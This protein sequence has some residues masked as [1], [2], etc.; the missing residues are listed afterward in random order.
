MA[1]IA[2]HKLLFLIDGI[3]AAVTSLLLGLVL[4]ALQPYVGISRSLLFL[5]SSIAALFAI[6]SL[7]HYSQEIE[8]W[9]P[10]LRGIAVANLLYCMITAGILCYYWQD[11]QLLG[12]L[13]FI[14]EIMVITVLAAIELKKASES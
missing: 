5:L 14:I 7:Y 10:R 2:G 8:N 1:K 9:R 3:G 6:Y 11:V 12:V 4:T 13:Y